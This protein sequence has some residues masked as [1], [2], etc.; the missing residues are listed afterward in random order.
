[1]G[2]LFIAI[3]VLIIVV[4]LFYKNDDNYE[5]EEKEKKT[6]AK[7]KARYHDALKG[8]DK[9]LALKYGRDYYAYVNNSRKLS[10]ED[11]QSIAQD[12]ASMK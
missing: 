5:K 9:E 2:S 11:E 3:L 6:I 8:S 10:R 1:M 12:L 4:S 7:L